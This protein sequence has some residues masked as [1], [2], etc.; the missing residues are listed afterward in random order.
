MVL[1]GLKRI[2]Q[3]PSPELTSS[4]RTNQLRSKTIYS[5]TVELSNALAIPGS[6]RYKTYNGPFEVVNKNGNGSLVAS[7]SYRDLLDITKGKVLLNQLPLTDLTYPYYEKNF[8]NGEIYVGNYQQFDGSFFNG[9]GPTGCADSVL[10]Y[11]LSTTGFTGPGSYTEN[12]IGNTGP[13]G[14]VGSNQNIF[15]DPKHCYYS[16]PCTSS[17]SYLK[18][19]DINFKG[20]TGATG[21]TGITG[22]SQYYAQQIISGNQYNGFRFPMSNFTL[23]CKQLNLSQAEGPIFC[24]FIITNPLIFTNSTVTIDYYDTLGNK[25]DGP[26]PGGYAVY[27]V[28]STI[29]VATVLSKTAQTANFLCIGGGGGGGSAVPIPGPVITGG[30]VGGGGGGGGFLSSNYQFS[31]NSSVSISVGLGGTGGTSL[32]PAVVGGDTYI[33]SNIAYGGGQGG[34]GAGGS[35]GV[36]GGNGGCGGG[37]AGELGLFANT[38]GLGTQGGDGENS[39][40]STGSGGGGGGAGASASNMHGGIGLVYS[41]VPYSGGVIY[42]GG[43]ASDYG[44]IGGTG[45]GGNPHSNGTNGLGG[46]GGGGGLYQIV[47]GNGGSGILILTIST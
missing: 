21:A 40:N 16:G 4:E 18:F 41:S 22:P 35:L 3:K 37:A 26:I 12:S 39:N 2:F 19:V 30:L 32:I 20:P 11:D 23:T 44:G 25:L 24:P 9:A 17:A 27:N 34:G 14:N 36:N 8:G 42:G 33:D 7:A 13:S 43:G 1:H 47:G 38:R 5:G 15:V 6:N 45:G 46:G 29:G 10:V 31:S 28:L